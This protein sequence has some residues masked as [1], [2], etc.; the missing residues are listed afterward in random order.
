MQGTPSPHAINNYRVSQKSH[1]ALQVP[2]P[3]VQGAPK[4]PKLQPPGWG[5]LETSDHG[6]VW[7]RPREDEE[8]HEGSMTE[9]S[10]VLALASA[11]RP[12]T[13]WWA[14]AHGASRS[15]KLQI[16]IPEKPRGKKA[17]RLLAYAGASSFCLH[18]YSCFRAAM[19]NY[20]KL[21]NL[22]TWFWRPEI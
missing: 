7:C 17:T 11:D 6:G 13:P 5:I 4:A 19:M 8:E 18:M 10:V 15:P 3:S 20:C 16:Q 9:T 22:L 14:W 21:G 1:R 2:V 12:P